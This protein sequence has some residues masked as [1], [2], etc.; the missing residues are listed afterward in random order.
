MKQYIVDA[1][2]EEL[3]TGNQAA[4]LNCKEMPSAEIMQKIAVENNYSETAFIVKRREGHYD[5]KWFTPKAEIRLCGHATLAAAFTISN[6]ID[7]GIAKMHFYT[8]SGELIVT[9]ENELYTLDFPM[10]DLHRV[11][12]TKEMIAATDGLAKEA[13]KSEDEQTI[14]ILTDDEDKIEQFEPNADKIIGLG[15][16]GM[17]ITAPSK[18]YDFVSRCFFPAIGVLEDPVTGSAHTYLAPFWQKH[19]HKDIMNAKQLSQRGGLLTVHPCGERVHISGK[20][21]LFMQG[22]ITL[23]L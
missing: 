15:R 7:V 16:H 18:R 19:L 11:T 5:L 4:V 20:A 17:I 8:L 21:V 1:F 6:F 12:L 9:R 22:E 13:Y 10:G 3:F 14:L 23:D 2:A